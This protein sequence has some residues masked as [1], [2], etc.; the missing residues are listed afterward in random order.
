MKKASNIAKLRTHRF[1]IDWTYDETVE[2]NLDDYVFFECDYRFDTWHLVGHICDKKTHEWSTR[3]LSIHW[4]WEREIAEFIYQ[5]NK[6]EKS[7]DIIHRAGCRVSRFNNLHYSS[8]FYES[9]KKVLNIVAEME[10]A[11]KA[12]ESEGTE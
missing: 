3:E 7:K 1:S 2:I 6:Y 9:L 8:G 12:K 10:E 5:A 4:C 11:D